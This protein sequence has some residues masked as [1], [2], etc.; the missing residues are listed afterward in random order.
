MTFLIITHVPH[1]LEQNQYFAYA[2][3][4]REM[5]IWIQQTDKLII[6]APLSKSPKTPIEIRYEHENIEFLDIKAF[7]VLSLKAISRSIY[8]I[9]AIS[10]RI[11]TSMQKA[12]HI[13]LRCPGNVGLLGCFVQI[14]FPNKTKTAKYAGNWDPKSK[15]PWTYKLQ[16]W[17]LGNPFLTRN[18]QVLVYGQWEGNSKNIKPFFT[19]TY[20]E[21]DKLPIINKNPNRQIHFVFVG[22]LV[23]GKNPFY[24][25]QLVE[26]LY[27]K[28]HDVT[29]SFYGE[30][31]E[32]NAL[33]QYIAQK[34]LEKIVELKGNQSQEII[35]NAYEYSHFVILPSESEGWPKAIAEGMFWGCVP[36]ATS[37]SCVPFMLDYGNRGV[38]LEMD[39]EKDIMQIEAILQNETAYQ[40][41][42]KNASDW[43]RQ[44][45]MDVFEEEVKKLLVPK[46]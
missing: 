15:Q 44:Y 21:A 27:K 28:G 22:T 24:V 31:T 36:L 41:K 9:P 37:V 35:K 25:I 7:D 5:N 46:G 2:P 26:A 16:K 6:V 20:S 8:K 23:Q 18:M 1:I 40:N 43:S 12:D 30:G 34:N 3:Y 33:E 19:A 42:S 4:V 17:I 45:T 39:L 38:L 29:L 13:H 11:F 10:G 32:R 14:L